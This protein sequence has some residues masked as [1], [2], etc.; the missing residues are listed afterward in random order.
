M[1]K[2]SVKLKAQLLVTFVIVSVVCSVSYIIYFS[3]NKEACCVLLDEKE[4]MSLIVKPENIVIDKPIEDQSTE[5]IIKDIKV[6]VKKID[7]N[8]EILSH[9]EK[10]VI[11]KPVEVIEEQTTEE[12]I[13]EI[14]VHIKDI[15]KNVKVISAINEDIKSINKVKKPE[16]DNVDISDKFAESICFSKI[17]DHYATS[18]ANIKTVVKVIS[19]EAFA[20]SKDSIWCNA[21][22]NVSTYD[23]RNENSLMTGNRMSESIHL[24]SQV[25]YQSN[26]NI[27]YVVNI[28][29]SEEFIKAKKGKN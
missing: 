14:K 26:E 12:I 10:I 19:I 5:E 15:K 22:F 3:M 27:E 24:K 9:P 20:H 6:I 2:M 11:N 16:S 29:P 23:V 8:I 1:S 18:D 25:P 21:S 4:E 28:V 13:K 7:D 17:N